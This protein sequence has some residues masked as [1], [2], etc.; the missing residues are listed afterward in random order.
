MVI[1]I[2]VINI[3]FIFA[4]LIVSYHQHHYSQYTHNYFSDKGKKG[5]RDCQYDR[6]NDNSMQGEA[7]FNLLYENKEFT[8]EQQNDGPMGIKKSLPRWCQFSR[9]VT[10]LLW[11]SKS[12]KWSEKL[13]R[14][15]VLYRQFSL[16]LWWDLKFH[17]DN[18]LNVLFV[19]LWHFICAILEMKYHWE[20]IVLFTTFFLCFLSWTCFQRE[21]C[22]W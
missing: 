22:N 9:A 3:Y 16:A 14:P 5:S 21:R 11:R 13:E 6:K 10:I 12:D 1:V 2:F 8:F 15:L 4:I 19:R 20:Y 7:S 17:M 18:V